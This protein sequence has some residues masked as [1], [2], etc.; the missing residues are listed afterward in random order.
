MES[1]RNRM[2]LAINSIILVIF[3]NG[4]ST[5]K[6]KSYLLMNLKNIPRDCFLKLI[7]A[8]REEDRRGKD[9]IKAT[10]R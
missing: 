9:R 5:A 10:R 8:R 1:I 7:P 4:I 2:R 3:T 6:E